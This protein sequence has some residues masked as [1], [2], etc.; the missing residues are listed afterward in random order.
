LLEQVTAP[1]EEPEALVAARETIELAFIAAVQHLPP[2]QRAALIL[3][4]V[5]GWSAKDTAAL[6]ETTVASADSALQRARTTLRSRPP[7]DAKPS[8]PRRDR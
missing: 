8:T 2:R 6:M 3:R 7:A 5:V 4:D 1:E